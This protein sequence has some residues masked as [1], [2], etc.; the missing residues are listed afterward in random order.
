MCLKITNSRIRDVTNKMNLT[1]IIIMGRVSIF[2][3]SSSIKESCT[4]K[5]KHDPNVKI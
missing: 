4:N 5:L 3:K 2:I 1:Q